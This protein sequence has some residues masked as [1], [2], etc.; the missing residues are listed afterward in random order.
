MKKNIAKHI[1]ILLVALSFTSQVWA[2]ASSGCLS[3]VC[4]DGQ[5]TGI[6]SE[7]CINR[8]SVM[9]DTCMGSATFGEDYAKRWFRVDFSY[10]VIKLPAAPYDTLLEMSWTAIDT[11]FRYLRSAFANLELKYGAVTFKKYAPNFVDS[12]DLASKIYYLRFNNYVR[13]NSVMADLANIEEIAKHYFLSYPKIL[14]SGGSLGVPTT[15]K[16]NNLSI[17]PNPSFSSIKINNNNGDNLDIFFICDLSGK[18]I[19][20]K[21][22]IKSVEYTLDV[23]ALCSGKYFIFCKGYSTSFIIGH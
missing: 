8:D 13:V 16:K 14:D 2:Q 19:F 4:I 1:L 9:V 5:A 23:H 11:N 7:K 3:L 10:Y 22:G 12:T 21:Q 15:I 18:K 20:E 17:T 6:D